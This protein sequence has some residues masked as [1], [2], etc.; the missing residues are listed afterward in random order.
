MRFAILLAATVLIAPGAIA[1]TCKSFNSCG[2][3]S[4]HTDQGTQGLIAI[5]MVFLVK[6]FAARTERGCDESSRRALLALCLT[7]SANAA[8]VVSVGDGD[9]IRVSEGSNES[10]FASRALM[11]R[12]HPS[13]LGAPDQRHS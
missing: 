8:T 6:A 5:R 2:K 4:G 13:A 9:T 10:L 1:Q 7:T 11:R 12:N 3:Q